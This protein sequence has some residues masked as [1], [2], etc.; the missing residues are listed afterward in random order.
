MTLDLSR[1][2]EVGEC[3]EWHGAYGCGTTAHTPIVRKRV[4]GKPV[5]LIVAREVWLAAHGSIPAGRLIYRH[6]CNAKCVRLE[7][8][9][10][11]RRGDQLR[12][13]AALGLAGHRPSTRASITR[14]ARCRATTRYTVAQ[15]GQVKDLV[16]CGVLDAEISSAT[17][18]GQAMVADI[19][20]GKA[21][22]DTT[23]AG[24]VFSWRPA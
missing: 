8:L 12:R 5:N 13:R 3:H 23:P 16:A 11:G 9:R 14:S 18:V 2:D 4:N 19:R 20:R 15:A 6:C 7:H 22:R 21:W 1:Y 17:G 24:S 10:C